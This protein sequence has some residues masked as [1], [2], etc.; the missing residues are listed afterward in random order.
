MPPGKRYMTRRAILW[1]GLWALLVLA[2]LGLV[3]VPN[4]MRFTG[5]LFLGTGRGKLDG[6]LGAALP[7]RE[8][9]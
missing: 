3:M 9:L 8:N 1:G 2:G 7:D 4:G 6:T 5:Y